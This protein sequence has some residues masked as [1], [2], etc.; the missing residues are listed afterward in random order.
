MPKLYKRIACV[1][2]GNKIFLY[3]C[4]SA[5]FKS[6]FLELKDEVKRRKDN[7]RNVGANPN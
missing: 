3:P 7:E 1:N 2:K 5:I 6:Y 4:T